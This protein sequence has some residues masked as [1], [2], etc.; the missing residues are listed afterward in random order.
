MKRP[1]QSESAKIELWVHDPRGIVDSS[2]GSDRVQ[3]IK[4]LVEYSDSSNFEKLK[5]TFSR[6]K[7]N[8]EN[9]RDQ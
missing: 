6:K 8:P 1:Q 9:L 5:W 2:Q 4:Y 3:K 7:I